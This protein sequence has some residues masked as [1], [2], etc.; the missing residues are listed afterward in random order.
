MICDVPG[1]E[2]GDEVELVLNGVSCITGD[3][4]GFL[5]LLKSG[6]GWVTNVPYFKM[7]NEKIKRKRG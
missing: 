3:S 4:F 7:K 1:S 6:A 5:F 2:A